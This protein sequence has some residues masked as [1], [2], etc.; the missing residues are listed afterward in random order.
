MALSV[1]YQQETVVELDAHV[2]EK[3]LVLDLRASH[4][5][6]TYRELRHHVEVRN[7]EHA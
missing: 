3:R 4:D 5:K 2:N 1:E 7:D 6:E